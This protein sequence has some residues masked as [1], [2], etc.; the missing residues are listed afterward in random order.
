MYNDHASQF[1]D[2]GLT[3]A[4]LEI[5][6]KA[7]RLDLANGLLQVPRSVRATVPFAMNTEGYNFAEIAPHYASYSSLERAPDRYIYPKFATAESQ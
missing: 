5:G 7:G 4:W 3:W 1:R 6:P 2:S